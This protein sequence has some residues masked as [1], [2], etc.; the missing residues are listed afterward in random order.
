MGNDIFMGGIK[1]TPDFDNIGV[2][3]QDQWHD[4]T[5]GKG[6][7]QIGV[8]YQPSSVS[9]FMFRVSSYERLTKLTGPISDYRRI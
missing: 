8:A 5:G 7:I 3:G 9:D 2:V 6:K 4:M 1:F